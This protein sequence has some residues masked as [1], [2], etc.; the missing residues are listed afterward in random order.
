M[1]DARREGINQRNI[2]LRGLVKSSQLL[3]TFRDEADVLFVPMSFDIDERPNMEIGFPSKLTD[4]TAVGVPLLIY[5]PA[6]CSAVRWALEN[7]G[8]AEVVNVEGTDALQQ[9]ITR[10][11]RDPALRKAL[12]ARALA[13]GRRAFAPEVATL[14]LHRALTKH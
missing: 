8:V 11:S 9:V 7:P 10:L 1:E 4:Y 5:G 12:G 13:V 6:Y 2:E 3:R 14:T